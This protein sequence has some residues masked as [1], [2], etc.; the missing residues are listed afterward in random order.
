[1]SEQ[2]QAA[3]G[4]ER[5]V[6]GSRIG[7]ILSTI[8]MAFGLGAIWRFP[9]VA[10]ESGGGAFVLAFTI[11]T[12]V[13]ALPAGWAEIAFARKMRSGP[14]TAFQKVLGKKGKIAWIFP[15]IP[16]GLNMYYLVVV[17]WTLAYTIFSLYCGQDFMADSVGF[18]QSFTG[19]RL[20]IFGW[21]VV[22]LLI[23]S[24]VCMK[25]IQKG[26]EKFCKFCIPLHYVI[27][28]AL[29]IRVLTLPGIEDGLTMFA[30]PDMSMLLDPSLW[31]RATGMALFAVGLGPAYLMAY[32]SYL[33]EK[34]D[35]PM[36][37]LTV[38]WWNLFGC[39]ASGLVVIPA[40]VAFGLNLQSGPSLTYV[41]LPYVFA[42][43]PFSGL[44]AFLF[45]FAM[46]L[47]GLSAAIGIMEN[48][49]TTFSD[50]L[51]WSRK[52][53]LYTIIVVTII[54]SIPCIW[55]DSFLA[56]F[57]YIIGDLGYTL[58]AAIMAI[59]L[60]WCVGAKKIRTEWLTGSS[61]P[62]GRWF[63]VIYKYAVVPIL[64]FLLFQSLLNIPKIFF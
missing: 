15:F 26:V 8:G 47:G 2:T 63:D 51:G 49:V 37:F 3:N 56:K 14:I 46:L 31:A 1:M 4:Q 62:L 52:K 22:T 5:E 41:T 28:F 48:S 54:R 58:T 50:G 53:T 29:V 20:A 17:S 24:F 34:S 11:V 6:W 59:V 10:A 18:F 55:S 32:G 60:A 57:D 43:M 64:L 7:F 35:I 30:K 27:L 36:D 16:L 21:T 45:F 12:I 19:N 33:P 9:Y 23:I 40:V 44:I 39:I 13:I 25:G 61:L 42:Q 38:A